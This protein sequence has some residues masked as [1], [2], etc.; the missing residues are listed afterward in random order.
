VLFFAGRRRSVVESRRADEDPLTQPVTAGTDN[1]GRDNSLPWKRSASPASA[2]LV[3]LGENNVPVDGPPMP[4]LGSEITFGR[5]PALAAFILESPTVDNLH[6]RL[7]SSGGVYVLADNGS[8]AGTWVNYA[9]I[10]R[11]GIRLE[12]GDIIHFGRLAFRFLLNQ[13]GQTRQP[14]VRAVQ[15]PR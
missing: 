4:L 7:H 13:P 6:A 8:V 3:P 10:S 12:H 14:T 2:V 9:P 15:M 5:D 1:R 11:E